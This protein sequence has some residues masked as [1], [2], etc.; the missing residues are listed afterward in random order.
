MDQDATWYGG[1]TV[2]LGSRHIVLNEDPAPPRNGA[3]QPP[4]SR[5]TT[6]ACTT[7]ASLCP[8][9]QRPGPCL[10]WPNSWTDQ[11]ATWY[12]SRPRPRRH[13]IRWE[14]SSP[15]GNWHNSTAPTFRPTLL[16][17]GRPSQQLLSSCNLPY[18]HLASSFCRDI[19][20]QKTKVPGLS[21]SMVCVSLRLAVL[22]EH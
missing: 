1:S 18:L 14:P 22:V 13:C 20:H 5:F 21:C 11:D 4:L 10:L 9:K 2:V 7:Q 17:H 12:G 19:R 3:Q 15:Q 6:Q 16:W 8:Y